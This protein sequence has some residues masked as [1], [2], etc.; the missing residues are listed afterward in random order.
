MHAH[1]S[2]KDVCL[3]IPIYEPG[4][5]RLFR[6]PHLKASVGASIGRKGRIPFVQALENISFDIQSGDRVALVGHNGSGKTTLLKVLARIYE[7]DSGEIK[8]SGSIGSILDIGTA[9]IED[10][11][12]Y[13]CIN[14]Y[15]RYK[16]L[17]ND[18]IAALVADMEEFTELGDFLSLP[19]RTYSAGMRS[20]LS[21]GLATSLTYDI[22]LI[23]EGIGAGD[24]EFQ[25]RFKKRVNNYLESAPILMLASH[26]E[27]MLRE[28]C[29]RGLV[30][31][32]GQLKFTGS[33]DE[34]LDYYA[35]S[36]SDRI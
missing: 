23:D 22:L 16:Q 5:M 24:A 6:K 28:Y 19:V 31:Q 18:A 34:A 7:P 4:S 15:C 32:H 30:L 35:Q 8:I 26:S 27:A 9:L 29:N 2:A 12:G 20:R 21:A 3:D 25:E 10:L 13:E 11:T 1:I 14:L 17:P 33:V 36:P